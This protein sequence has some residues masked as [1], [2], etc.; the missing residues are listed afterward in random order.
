MKIAIGIP[1]TTLT[2]LEQVRR[3]SAYEPKV[4]YRLCTHCGREAFGGAE[5]TCNCDDLC[6]GPKMIV[7]SVEVAGK[8]QAWVGKR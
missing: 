1:F 8:K 4:S 6:P 5:L 3:R 7:Q 2:L